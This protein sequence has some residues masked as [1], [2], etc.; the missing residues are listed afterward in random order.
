MKSVGE[1]IKEARIKKKLSREKLEVRTKIKKEFIEAL[2]N[3]KWDLLPEYPVV[4]GFVKNI[5][6]NLGLKEANLIALL[7]RDYPPKTLPVNPKPEI[8]EKFKWSPRL[9][10]ITAAIFIFIIITFYL[11]LSYFN[12][13]RPPSL[14]IK[15][16]SENQLVDKNL[17]VVRGN[18][19]PEAYVEINNQPVIVEE[20]GCFVTEIEIS[21][22]TQEI[23]VV[24]KSRSGKETI[25]HRKIEVVGNGE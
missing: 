6:S 15:E 20:D 9:T 25:V 12:F 22:E 13:I 11:G 4:L 1:I 23:V 2:E 19:N 5:A 8:R 17:L 7:R 16:P 14:E 3:S 10:F 24:A 21:D 18:T